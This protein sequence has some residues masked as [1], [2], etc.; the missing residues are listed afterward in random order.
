MLL[1][2]SVPDLERVI[3]FGGYIVTKVSEEKR[4]DA[5]EALDKEFKAKTKSAKSDEDKDS[6]KSAFDRAKAEI[7]GLNVLSVISEVEYHRLSLKYGDVF[8]AGI[9]AEALRNV[10]AGLD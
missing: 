6:L 2:I 1:G 10:C 4:K 8:E 9:G 5:L 3:Y 7:K